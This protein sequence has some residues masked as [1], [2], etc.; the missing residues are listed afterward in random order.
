MSA[1]LIT[2]FQMKSLLNTKRAAKILGISVET[3]RRRVKDGKIPYTK[4]NGKTGHYRFMPEDI[5][6]RRQSKRR[7]RKRS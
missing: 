7:K 2:N 5:E 3:L 6:R 4:T 1:K